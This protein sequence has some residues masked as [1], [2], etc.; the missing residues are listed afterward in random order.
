MVIS[1]G[2]TL[3]D[4]A[5]VAALYCLTKSMM[6]TAWG[7]R[8]VPTGGAGVAAPAGS[9]ILMT[10]ATLRRRV[11]CGGMAGGRSLTVARSGC[12]LEL[13][14]LVEGELDRGLA[15]EDGDQYLELLLVDVDLRD[16]A[17]ELSERS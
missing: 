8:A 9:S 16:R 14:D 4:C 1:T 17:G 12:R 10:A 5:A 6:F 3:P 13:L 2:M 15:A 11:D 7:P